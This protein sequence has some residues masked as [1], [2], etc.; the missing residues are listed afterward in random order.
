MLSLYSKKFP[1][2]LVVAEPDIH[3]NDL[4]PKEEFLVLASDGLWDV[5]DGQTAVKQV[6]SMLTQSCSI[7]SIAERLALEAIDLG[8][9]DN[10]T[11]IIITF[12]D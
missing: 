6:Q 1:A 3:V 12:W 4:T 9:S 7:Q 8:S 10:I 5:M 2:D 11:V